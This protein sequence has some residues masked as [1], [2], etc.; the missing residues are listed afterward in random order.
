M[1]QLLHDSCVICRG[2]PLQSNGAFQ[3]RYG[4][5]VPREP[6]QDALCTRI[7]EMLSWEAADR[8][9]VHS[10]PINITIGSKY[11]THGWFSPP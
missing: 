1:L 2:G 6:D 11:R 7:P 4:A 9:A 5:H 3:E 10:L 8:C